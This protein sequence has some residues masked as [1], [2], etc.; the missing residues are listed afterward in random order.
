MLVLNL[1]IFLF[2]LQ[3]P[4][5]SNLTPKSKNVSYLDIIL[6]Q[7]AHFDIRQI[8]FSQKQ[9]IENCLENKYIPNA[10]QML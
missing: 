10:K 4:K 7:L 5:M 1:Y 6:T 2:L 3:H 8:A 9:I